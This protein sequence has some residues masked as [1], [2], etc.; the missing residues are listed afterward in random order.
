MNQNVDPRNIEVVC[1]EIAEA[2]R[3]KSAAERIHMVAEAN[4]TARLLA[5]AGARYV[6]PD[7][8]AEQVEREVARRMLGAA[9]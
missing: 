7:W 8:S 6:N 5:A 9:N 2:L 3:G 4:D 1:D